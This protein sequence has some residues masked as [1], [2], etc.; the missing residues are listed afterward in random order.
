[1]KKL[2]LAIIGQGRS[3]KNI[4]GA[5]Y[6][7]KDNVCYS[8]KYVVD[9]D[10]VMREKAEKL[11]FGC[12]TLSDYK[13]LFGKGDID[14]VVNASYSEMHFSITEDLINHGFNVLCEK[15]F[16]RTRR[17]CDALI[18][19]AKEKGVVL[20]VFQ[21][22]FPAPYVVHAREIADSGVL[23]KIEQISIR[24]NGFARRWD[25][26]TLQ[27]KVAGSAYN[28]GPHPLG[29][30]LG[31]LDFDPEYR[32]AYSKLVSSSLTSGDADDYDKFILTAPNKP[33]VDVEISALDAYCDYNLKIQGDKGTLKS[34]TDEYKYKY[35][36]DGENPPRP[37]VEESLRNAEHEPVYCG[38]KL[39]FHEESGKYDRTAFDEGTARIYQ[40]TYEAIANG[41]PI[42]LAE[43]AA[44]IIDVI[45]RAHKD[46][47]LQIKF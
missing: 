28:T 36:V 46:N 12:R 38:E 44:M 47:P 20:S 10:P 40:Q 32:L 1:M 17:E 22:T 6:R 33:V 21:N 35:I 15:P 31:F 19:L 11:Y 5:Y 39:V 43:K 18:S 23:G 45:E 8:V 34:T 7:S 9:K 26:Q 29:I 25:W 3:G 14:L 4:H 42:D 2:N 16:A 24:F 13:E 37:V 30:A 41:K 27:K